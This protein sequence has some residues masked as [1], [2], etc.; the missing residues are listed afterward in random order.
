MSKLLVILAGALITL[1][2]MSA[3]GSLAAGQVFGIAF[4]VAMVCAGAA[5]LI[6]FINLEK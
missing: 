3:A 1:A 2:T 5:A 6:G 4:P